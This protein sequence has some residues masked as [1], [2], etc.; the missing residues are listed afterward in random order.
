MT[1][2]HKPVELNLKLSKYLLRWI[3]VIH[4]LALFA[5]LILG[6]SLLIGFILQLAIVGNFFLTYRGWQKPLCEKIVCDNGR[7]SLL[8]L[9]VTVED[10]ELRQFY[11]FGQLCVISFKCRDRRGCRAL[12]PILLL[13]DSCDAASLRQLRQLLLQRKV[14]SPNI[15]KY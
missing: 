6:H 10:V 7:F 2:D 14:C 11:F 15:S 9:G 4:A 8:I 3:F 5:V 12:S 1:L 13:P